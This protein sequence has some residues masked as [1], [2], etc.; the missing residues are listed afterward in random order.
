MHGTRGSVLAIALLIIAALS[1]TAVALANYLSTETRLMRYYLAQAQA[2]A[3]AKAGVI[4]AMERLAMDQDPKRQ[5]TYDWLGDEWA[6]FPENKGNPSEWTVTLPDQSH[7]TIRMT[8]EERKRALKSADAKALEDVGIRQEIAKVIVDYRTAKNAE[9]VRIEEV[10]KIPDITEKERKA[11]RDFTSPVLASGSQI[12]INTADE[13]LLKALFDT[14][15]KPKLANQVVTYR[16]DPNDGIGVDDGNRFIE[17]A[18]QPKVRG[19]PLDDGLKRELGEVMGGPLRTQLGVQSQHFAVVV[20]A[21]MTTPSIQYV[22]EAVV[23]RMA[24]TEP[25]IKLGA[26]SHEQFRILMW[27]E[28]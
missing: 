20:T 25:L 7:V 18:S 16:W 27:R 19:R 9:I 12:N 13:Q 22:V 8:D 4:L 15:S 26:A 1:A 5:E 11:L 17:L 24:T 14:A 6:Y 21:Q 2:R 3:W 23:Q 28:D 10:Y